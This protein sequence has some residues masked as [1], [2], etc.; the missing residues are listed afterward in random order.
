MPQEEMT[1]QEMLNGQT[2]TLINPNPG[3]TWKTAFDGKPL[4]FEP[5]VP[6]RVEVGTA[7]IL[8]SMAL[9]DKSN[10]ESNADAER[11]AHTKLMTSDRPGD[12]LFANRYVDHNG[13][14]RSQRWKRPPVVDME[15]QEGKRLV[16]E[17]AAEEERMRSGNGG[18]MPK[19]PVKARPLPM[20]RDTWTKEQLRN[21]L[22]DKGHP[23]QYGD[24]EAKLLEKCTRIYATIKNELEMA[25]IEVFDAQ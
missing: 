11:E 9:K 5:L 7:R 12:R 13:Q 22:K 19:T 6:C 8:L 24:D 23:V 14:F 20:P 25:G 2:M 18:E 3:M 15:S 10:S 17:A 4:K 21:Y 1:P 16:A